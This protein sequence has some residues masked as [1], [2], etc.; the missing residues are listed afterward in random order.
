MRM[1]KHFPIFPTAPA[2]IK[3]YLDLVITLQ[4]LTDFSFSFIV[5]VVV[6]AVVTSASAKVVNP[7]I[8]N[9]MNSKDPKILTWP[10][11]MT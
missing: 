9:F 3:N 5:I 7:K 2:L 11:M 4:I 8:T 6:V 1:M 10:A